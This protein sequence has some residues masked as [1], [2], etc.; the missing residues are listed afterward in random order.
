MTI[1]RILEIEKEV[2]MLI[3]AYDSAIDLK[4]HREAA[5]LLIRLDKIIDEL[6][7]NEIKL[8]TEKVVQ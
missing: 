4:C 6:D 3:K 2:D 1:K 7:G 8:T 5:S